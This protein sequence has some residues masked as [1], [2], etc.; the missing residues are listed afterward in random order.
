MTIVD[1]GLLFF[2]QRGSPLESDNIDSC[3]GCSASEM[4]HV[5]GGALNSTHSLLLVPCRNWTPMEHLRK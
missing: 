1:S 4:T 2:F 5:S 3:R